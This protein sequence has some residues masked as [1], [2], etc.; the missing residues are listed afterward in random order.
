MLLCLGSQG[1]E[2]G[3]HAVGAAGQH[4]RAVSC[5]LLPPRWARRGLPPSRMGLHGAGLRVLGWVLTRALLKTLPSL[6]PVLHRGLCLPWLTVSPAPVVR[7]TV[8]VCHLLDV[9]VG[10]GA[11]LPR[12][13]GD[14]PHPSA[15]ACGRGRALGYEYTFLVRVVYTEP[16]FPL[17]WPGGLSG[18]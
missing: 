16:L 3:L 17:S 13:L 15:R 11:P 7:L 1:H 18:G 12:S 14:A 2:A 8:P 10:L 6:C 9:E 4:L 5:G